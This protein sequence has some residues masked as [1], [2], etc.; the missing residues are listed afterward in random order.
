MAKSIGIHFFGLNTFLDVK[1]I[2]K[3]KKSFDHRDTLDQQHNPGVQT[4]QL[5]LI[6]KYLQ[7]G[8]FKFVET[9]QKYLLINKDPR[10]V[11]GFVMRNNL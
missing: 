11:K 5:P 10:H 9:F 8:T 3:P 2:P 4:I 6:L 1:E 7:N